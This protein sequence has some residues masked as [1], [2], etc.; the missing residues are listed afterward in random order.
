MPML[1]SRSS[2]LY[3]YCT[4]FI[5]AITLASCSGSRKS[6]DTPAEL[7]SEFPNH[8]LAQIYSNLNRLSVP[9][10]S[11]EAETSLTVRSPARNGSFSA[12]IWHRENDSLL[13]NV[14]PGF[15]IVAVKTLITPDSFFVHDR[16]NRELTVGQLASL[17]SI[18]PLPVTSEDIYASML[19]L[20][21]PE[22]SDDWDLKSD[23]RYYT[24]SGSMSN[25]SY[26]IDPVYWR[27][28]RYEERSSSGSLIEE[29]TFSEFENVEGVYLPRRLTFRRPGDKTSASIYFRDM[30]INPNALSFDFNV[31]PSVKR[32][33]LP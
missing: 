13:I 18:L 33:N 10:H 2:A 31:S 9:L 6:I 22:E 16:I 19:G 3:L 25:Q 20:L 12:K 32:I 4:L 23:S 1:S 30:N 17:Q 28:V 24:L 29:R 5:I 8:T 14:S 7:P 26:F 21:A 11:Y 15:G 27:V